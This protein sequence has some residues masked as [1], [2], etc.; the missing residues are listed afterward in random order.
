M[1]KCDQDNV[2]VGSEPSDNNS[3]KKDFLLEALGAGSKPFN[4]YESG[5]VAT[6]GEKMKPSLKVGRLPWYSLKKTENR[7]DP[8]HS[9][10]V[11]V[12]R[13]RQL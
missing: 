7:E 10:R 13:I 4:N 12:E 6:L 5:Y 8:Y 9:D 2:Q 11:K 1:M 3:E